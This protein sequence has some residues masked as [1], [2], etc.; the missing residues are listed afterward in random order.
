MTPEQLLVFSTLLGTLALFVWGKWRYDVVG[1]IALL[2]LVITG[3]VPAK[4][5][6]IGFSEPAVITVA[7]VLVISKALE[8]S[9]LVS[10]LVQQLSR[11]GQSLILQILSLC[12]VVGF[13]SSFMNNVGAL[14]LMMPVAITLANKAGRS[15]GMV[16][17]PLAFASL[18][19]GMTTLIGTPPNLIISN[20]RQ[21]LLGQSFTMFSYFPVGIVVA[22]VGLLYLTFLGWRLLPKRDSGAV[23]DD[24]YRIADY[25]TEVRV[26]AESSLIDKKIQTLGER[27]KG[28]QVVSLVRTNKERRFP[29]PSVKLREGD[30]L[31]IEA[32]ADDLAELVQ[33]KDLILV[34][35][36]KLTPEQ[37]ASDDVGI[38]EMVVTALSP[39]VSQT[40]IKL[41]LRQR[42]NVNLL[43]ISR[44]GKRLTRRLADVRFQ[45][46]DVLLLQGPRESL[47]NTTSTLGCLPLRE[48]DLAIGTGQNGKMLLTAGL[49]VA[50]IIISTLGLLPTTISFAIAALLML[51]LKLINLREVY[52]SI[53]WPIL[54]LLATL[55]PVGNAFSSTGGANLIAESVLSLSEGWPVMLT[56]IVVMVVVMT[57]SD[58]INNAAA[59]LI[60]APIVVKIAQGLDSNPDAFLVAV[61]LAASSAFLTPIGHQSNTL[62]MGPGGY[63]FADYWKMGLPLELLVIAVGAPAIAF[64]WKL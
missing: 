39:I 60:T 40:V 25:M 21:E 57:L 34:G 18:L 16:L 33:D 24:L 29:L 42:F 12:A 30:V 64:F 7:A 52:E 22:V 35:S 9:G 36:E 41:R 10:L 51:M 44:Q 28:V 26:P 8:K 37:L 45:A 3:P 47:S 49:F 61:A 48:R 31:I 53:E 43:A 58:I 62:V 13:L 5:A 19:G 50:A 11:V 20:Q 2:T 56:L 55:I 63:K 32:T 27:V 59:A 46:G 38:S 17:M 1:M 6:F 54:V 23:R 15:A 14:A 4:E